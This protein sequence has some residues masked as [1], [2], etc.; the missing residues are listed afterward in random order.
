MKFKQTLSAALVTGALL[1]MGAAQA[2][3]VRIGTQGDALS[4][5]PHSLNETTAAQRDRQRLRAAGHARQGPEPDSGAGHWLEA[6]V[7]HGLALRT[8]QGRPVPRRHAFHRR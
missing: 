5:D 2:Q 4:M 6:D 1:A 3:T 8:A 7:S